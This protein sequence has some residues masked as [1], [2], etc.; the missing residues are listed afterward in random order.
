VRT[1]ARP[2]AGRGLRVP[3]GLR[4]LVGGRLAQLPADVIDVLL[5]VSALARPTVELVAA[6]HGDVE[7]VRE[8]ISAAAAEEIVELDDSR[9]RFAHPLLASICYER[10]PVWKRRAI[11]RALAA[12]VLDLEER[13]R[14]LALSAEGPD[15]AVASELDRAADQAAARGATAAAADLCELAAGLTGDDPAPSRQ[16]RLRAAHFHRLAGDG[17]RAAALS[18]TCCRRLPRGLSVP[19]SCSSCSGRVDT[20]LGRAAS[21]SRKRW[22][23]R[24]ATTPGRRGCLL[25]KRGSCCGARTPPRH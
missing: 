25:C 14:H 6:A 9:V 15:A 1:Q 10:A 5:K 3:E 11:H 16:R 12:V 21:R 22:P 24:R 4:E 17:E 2:A 20:A 23:R 7:R 18:R 13:A 8:V 19:M